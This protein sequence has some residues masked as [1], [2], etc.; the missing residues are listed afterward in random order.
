MN[1]LM[2]VYIFGRKNL[3]RLF[4]F[5]S[6]FS[7]ISKKDFILIGIIKKKSIKADLVALNKIS[8]N[9]DLDILTMCWKLFRKRYNICLERIN[10]TQFLLLN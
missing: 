1:N 5:P 9:L 10:R 8:L 3:P 6:S 2:F 7:F 4:M